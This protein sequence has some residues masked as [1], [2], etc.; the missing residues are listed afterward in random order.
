MAAHQESAALSTLFGQGKGA[1]AAMMLFILGLTECLF[2]LLA[3]RKLKKY[4]FSEC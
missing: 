2:C 1:G 4:H 3:G